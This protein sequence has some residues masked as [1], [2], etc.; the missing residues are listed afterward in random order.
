MSDTA[1][2]VC[3]VQNDLVD[4]K[5]KVGAGGLAKIVADRTTSTDFDIP[6]RQGNRD[7]LRI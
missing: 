7:G 5:G 4:P 3:D 2:L 6:N 1:L